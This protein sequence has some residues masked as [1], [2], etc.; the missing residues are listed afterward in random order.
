MKIIV[1]L[2]G[3]MLIAV[4][5]SASPFLVCDP[6]AG[7]S[8]YQLTGPAWVPVTVPAQPDGSIKMDVSAAIVGSNAITVKAC[9][10][11]GSVWG[12][13]CSASVPFV[14]TRPAPPATT[15]NIRLS[16]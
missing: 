7:V 12:E 16:Q 10:S 14:F 3:L 5:V 1:I 15:S 8:S 4:A 2:I 9:A 13:Q 6:Q 11:A